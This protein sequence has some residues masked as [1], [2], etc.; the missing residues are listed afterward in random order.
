[1]SFG[2]A[3]FDRN[4]PAFDITG[5]G[6]A[7]LEH[8]RAVAEQTWHSTA[9]IPDHRQH[10]PLCACRKRPCHRAAEQ[11]DEL[12]SSHEILPIRVDAQLYHIA[13][14]ASQLISPLHFR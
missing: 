4:V 10:R 7:L 13:V 5:L 8:A 6:E 14:C 11:G 9:E 3:I 1:M 12:A 2:P